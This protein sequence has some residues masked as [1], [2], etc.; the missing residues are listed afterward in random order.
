MLPRLKVVIDSPAISPPSLHRGARPSFW[1]VFMPNVDLA[2]Y[3]SLL[4]PRALF[5]SINRS[6]KFAT[7]IQKLV[8]NSRRIIT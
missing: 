2:A 4:I 5:I 3:K 6:L 8:P 1:P 7:S